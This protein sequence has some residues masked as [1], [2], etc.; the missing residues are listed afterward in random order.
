MAVPDKEVVMTW[1]VQEVQDY[2]QRVSRTLSLINI[3]LFK[4]LLFLLEQWFN[5]L[6]SY[7][8]CYL[9]AEGVADTSNKNT[10][11]KIAICS[12]THTAVPGYT[13]PAGPGEPQITRNMLSLC[14]A[15]KTQ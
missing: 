11:L 1:G 5:I 7:K 10:T 3:E 15:N 14:L 4:S 6:F 8:V 9:T 2:L 12:P 13:L